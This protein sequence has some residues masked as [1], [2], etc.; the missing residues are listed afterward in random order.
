MALNSIRFILV[1]TWLVLAW[2][3][4]QAGQQLGFDKAGDYFFGDLSHPWRAQFN[5][6]FGIHLLLVA[7]WF[8]WSASNR[9]LGTVFA[10]LAVLGGD[11]FTLAYLLVRS[12]QTGGNL[13]A[14]VLGRHFEG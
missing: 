4:F 9:A 10:V 5:T 7:A 3:T 13:R 11:L 1:A 6:D 2:V 14:V 12:I 8:V